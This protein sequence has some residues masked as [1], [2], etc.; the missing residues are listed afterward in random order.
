MGS[1]GYMAPERFTG[2][3]WDERVDVYALA[4]V[5]VEC[6]LGHRPFQAESL[7]SVMHAHLVR[8]PPRPTQER[9]DLPV[10]LDDVVAHGMAKDPEARYPTAGALAEAAQAALR[11]A[12]G[13]TI[14]PPPRV[15]PSRD[16]DATQ[17]A[18]QA[19]DDTTATVAADVGTVTEQAGGWLARL[20]EGTGRGAAGGGAARGGD[21]TDRSGRGSAGGAWRGGPASSGSGRSTTWLGG[22]AP[23][24]TGGHVRPGLSRRRLLI[25]GG[26]AVGLAAAGGATWAVVA[27]NRPAGPWTAATGDKIY[28]S[29]LVDG[30]VVYIGS[31]DGHLYA[32]DADT[33]AQRWRYPTQGAVTSSPRIADGT[34]YVG[35]QDGFLHAVDVRTGE[36]RWATDTGGSGALVARGRGQPRGG[37]QPREQAAG[38]RRA[39]RRRPVGARARR[40]VQLLARDRRRRRLRRLPRPQ[41][42]RHRRGHRGAAVAVHDV[43]HGGLVAAGRRA[44]GVHRRRRQQGPLLGRPHRRVDLG[45]HGAEGHRLH[46]RG[47]RRRAVRGQRRRQPLRAGGRHRPPAVELPHA[48]GIRSSPLATSGLVVVGSHD[49][50]LHA[51]DAATGQ[52]RWRFL[53]AGPIDDS[54]PAYAD[55]LVYVGTLAGTVH[56]VDAQHGP[57]PG[58]I[59]SSRT[60]RPVVTVV[61][62]A[63]GDHRGGA[64]RVTGRPARPAWTLERMAAPFRPMCSSSARGPPAS[65]AA[66]WAARAGRDVV[67]ADAAVFP[68]DK[69]CGDG[70]TPRAIAELDRLGLG[71]WVRAHTVNRGLRATASARPCC[72]RGRAASLPDLRLGACRAPSSTTASAPRDR[73]RRHG[74]R[75]GRAVDVR[76]RGRARHRA[77]CSPR[78]RARSRSPASGWSSPT[79]CAPRW[80]RCWAASGTATRPTAWPARGYVDSGRSDDPWISCH[81]ELRGEEGEVLAGLRLDLPARRRRGEHRRR[82]ARHRS[83][84]RPTIAAAQPR[85]STTPTRAARTGSSTG[86]V[87][88]AH[89]RAAADGRR[90][91]ARRRAQLGADRRRRGLRQPAQ[92]RGHRLR[93]RDGPAVAELLADERHLGSGVA[94]RRCADHYGEAFS[95]ARRLAGLLTLPRLLPPLGPV[96]MRSTGVDDGRAA[97]MGN[98]VTDEDRD[99]TARA[100]RA[101]GRPSL[102]LDERPPFS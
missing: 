4:C 71:D 98:L 78:R 57:R 28:S 36:R 101:A 91:L 39:L 44:V 88:A 43:E 85:C 7:P 74:V 94:A 25:A 1:A 64:V 49:R 95:I 13:V 63:R 100:W 66:A 37:R 97:G 51:V 68:R 40:L 62:C 23:G 5:L 31:N 52:V 86:A 89:L 55:G 8:E 54:S 93:P 96:G 69:T 45:L 21:G 34:L 12:R 56:A 18:T 76:T 67:L 16:D 10:A 24:T 102:R 59:A 42:L 22:S 6:L 46:A 90:G 84:A 29:P 81:L 17:D 27:S 41:R 50:F 82:H 61:E 9:P 99:L 87:R 19:A 80:A 58:L 70:L 38:L 14:A 53:T 73:G 83:N 92:R 35:G 72:C 75:R 48:G 47:G 26:T 33:G 60:L 15:A 11:G 79:A 30:G 3:D 20:R 32:F 77:S 2:D 65:A